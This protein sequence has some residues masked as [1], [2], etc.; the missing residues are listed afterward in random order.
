MPE[1]Y[2]DCPELSGKTIQLLRIHRDTGDGTE[3][4]DRADGWNQFH[5][6]CLDPPNVEAS[7]YKGGVGTPETIRA[8]NCRHICAPQACRYV[9]NA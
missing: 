8:T 4:P 6:L 3:C 7:L 2:I 5:V 9:Q 1:D